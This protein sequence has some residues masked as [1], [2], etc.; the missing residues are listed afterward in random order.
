[1][2]PA[3]RGGEAQAS[4]PHSGLGESPAGT[5]TSDQ[6][7]APRRLGSG[8]GHW[9]LVASHYTGTVALLRLVLRDMVRGPRRRGAPAAGCHHDPSP[10]ARCRDEGAI[11]TRGAEDLKW[12]L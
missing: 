5:Q 3:R 11:L 9:Q 2:I 1:M 12:G 4:W 10:S 8:W 7:C 6:L